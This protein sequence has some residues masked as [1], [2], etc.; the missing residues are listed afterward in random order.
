MF[1]AHTGHVRNNNSIPDDPS[2]SWFTIWS[3]LRA[4]KLDII[5]ENSLHYTFSDY[6]I[7]FQTLG[8]VPSNTVAQALQVTDLD[9]RRALKI[10]TTYVTAFMDFVLY[11]KKSVLLEQPVPEFP[12]VIFDR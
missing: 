2:N 9:G 3:K 5:L 10:V 1:M 8:I 4:F 12:E 11:N 7:V 6:P